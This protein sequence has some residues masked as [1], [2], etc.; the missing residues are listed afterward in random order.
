VD[1]IGRRV[2]PAANVLFR[3]LGGEAVLLSLASGSYYGLN[4]VGARIWTLIAGGSDLAGVLAVLEAEYAAPVERLRSDLL[5][6]VEEL[7]GS[8]LLVVGEP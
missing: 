8:G 1:D 2:R 7:L 3:Q 4:E 5:E 6:I